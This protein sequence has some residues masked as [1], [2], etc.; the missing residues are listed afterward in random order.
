MAGFF[1]ALG[2]GGCLL[3]NAQISLESSQRARS[4]KSGRSVVV[5]SVAA[6]ESAAKKAHA[7]GKRGA[8]VPW[9]L[10]IGSNRWRWNR[11]SFNTPSRPPAPLP[12]STIPVFLSS[13][14]LHR[15]VHWTRSCRAS[16]RVLR[17]LARRAVG[18][19]SWVPH[20]TT[21]MEWALRGGFYG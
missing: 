4:G 8:T 20:C 11:I 5:Q 16:S 10:T 15:L 13:V 6:Y 2:R 19:I 17:A 7:V 1:I 14:S 12:P 3:R 21:G 9:P 18:L